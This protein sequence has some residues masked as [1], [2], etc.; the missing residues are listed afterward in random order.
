MKADGRYT[1]RIGT[2]HSTQSTFASVDSDGAKYM[3]VAIMQA[4][5][6]SRSD[7]LPISDADIVGGI[8]HILLTVP[9]SMFLRLPMNLPH[10]LAVQLLERLIMPFTVSHWQISAVSEDS[11]CCGSPCVLSVGFKI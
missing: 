7:A 10:P 3:S 1:C 6:H 9:V 2:H 11:S 4:Y 5:C 8:L